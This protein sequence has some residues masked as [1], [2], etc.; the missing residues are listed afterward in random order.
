TVLLAATSLGPVAAQTPPTILQAVDL[1]GLETRSAA[2]MLSAQEAGDLQVSVLAIPLPDQVSLMLEI[3]GESLLAGAGA[4]SGDELLTE[5]YAYAIDAEGG[6]VDTLTQAV[7]LDLGRHRAALAS[8]GLKFFGHLDL[9]PGKYSLRAMA[10]HRRANRLGLRISQLEVPRWSTDADPHLLPPVRRE[11]TGRWLVV[12]EEAANPPPFPL[13]VAG[14]SYVPTVRRR[15]AAQ[16]RAGFWLLGSRP[17][18]R[19]RADLLPREGGAALQELGLG[20]LQTLEGGRL[21]V[22]AL[23][24]EVDTDRLRPGE[25]RLQISAVERPEAFASTALEIRP[26]PGFDV[27]AAAVKTPE[28]QP[29]APRARRSQVRAEQMIRVR[30]AYSQS[31]AEL[32]QTHTKPSLQSLIELETSMIGGG[33]K[34]A[35]STLAEAELRV[36]LELTARDAEG[37]L[38]LIRIHEALYRRY[39]KRRHFLLA[40][41]SRQIVAS[42]SQLYL[43]RLGPNPE[44][45]R[46]VAAA[47]TSMAGYLQEIGA[48][49][50]AELTY[51]KALD[52]Q[53]DDRAALAG[54]AAI[55]EFYAD[56]EGAEEL[57][58]RLHANQPDDPH[59]RLRL[60]INQKR[61]GKHRRAA[62]TLGQS[63]A[64]SGPEWVAALAAQEL[65]GLHASQERFDEAVAV[66]EAAITRHPNCQRLPIQLAALLDRSGRPTA[67]R[68][69]LARLDPQAGRETSSPRLLYSQLPATA[70]KSA[71]RTLAQEASRRLS[72]LTLPAASEAAQPMTAGGF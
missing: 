61:L 17:E 2:L 26:P 9:P 42:L 51:E 44:G 33:S 67:A 22:R 34:K 10:L 5:I 39:H 40:T 6:L 36:A 8:T 55:R 48:M 49:P 43:E 11:L 28:L 3:G 12:H 54:L 16:E 27:P 29:R 21:G 50:S 14:K 56:Y 68:Q 4:E 24:A 30:A 59:I 57:L 25:Y 38:P 13:R 47:L 19:L 15:I 31:L 65:A 52:H 23:A 37:F 72:R 71:R 1:G 62:E 53:R 69:V 63:L 32:G 41:H 7:R 45:R 66:L 20:H 18:E 60:G 58:R 64:A 35:Q 46:L 70:A